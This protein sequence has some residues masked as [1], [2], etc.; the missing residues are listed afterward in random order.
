MCES[1]CR[2]DDEAPS[3][4][5]PSHRAGE[6]VSWMLAAQ[7]DIEVVGSAGDGDEAADLVV[8]TEPDV[9]RIDLSMPH[10]DGVERRGESPHRDRRCAFS[11]SCW[12]RFPIANASGAGCGCDQL[13]AEGRRAVRAASW[14][15]RRGKGRS[16]ADPRAAR[17]APLRRRHRDGTVDFR[18]RASQAGCPDGSTAVEPTLTTTRVQL[19][20][21]ATLG[22]IIFNC[23]V[24][25]PNGL[26]GTIPLTC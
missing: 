1:R 13:S 19:L 15:A 12:R 20:I 5:P 8:A 25:D 10:V 11:C 3:G 22:P 14:R 6:P 26:S 4:G 2:R 24:S 17:L 16:A 7:D 23:T 21:A 9:V 18:T